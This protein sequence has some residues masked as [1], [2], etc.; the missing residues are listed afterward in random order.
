MSTVM[1]MTMMLTLF[2]N[3]DS[4]LV[5]VHTFIKLNIYN[6]RWTT[7]ANE[8]LC[9]FGVKNL[10]AVPLPGWDATYRCFAGFIETLSTLRTI[11]SVHYRNKQKQRDQ[12]ER[13]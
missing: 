8:K 10:N 1:M 4:P 6:C 9:D 7:N 12:S 5:T 3:I 2:L 13:N 11:N